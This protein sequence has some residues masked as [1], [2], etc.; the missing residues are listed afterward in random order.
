MAT[1]ESAG[2]A[3][4]DTSCHQILSSSQSLNRLNTTPIRQVVL[5]GTIRQSIVRQ[6]GRIG[7]AS[8][9]NALNRSAYDNLHDRQALG[10]FLGHPLNNTERWR[11]ELL[12]RRFFKLGWE[13][14]RR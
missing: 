8:I 2:T 11:S 4:Q 7:D 10:W 3:N 13:V 5:L 1:D 12:L 14:V 6:I 9:Y